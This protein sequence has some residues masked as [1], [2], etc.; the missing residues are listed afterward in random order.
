MKNV[1][2]FLR[3][4]L[5]KCTHFMTEE[6]MYWSISEQTVIVKSRKHTIVK[7]MNNAS[8]FRGKNS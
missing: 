8:T 3:K 1:I 6:I 4:K 7:A 5:E 2:K